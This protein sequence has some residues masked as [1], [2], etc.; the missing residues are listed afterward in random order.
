MRGRASGPAGPLPAGLPSGCCRGPRHGKSGIPAWAFGRGI[1]AIPLIRLNAARRDPGRRHKRFAL[2]AGVGH[3]RRNLDPVRSDTQQHVAGQTA[4]MKRPGRN[5]FAGKRNHMACPLL[6]LSNRLAQPERFE[7]GRAAKA[8]CAALI[9]M[10]CVLQFKSGV[11]HACPLVKPPKRLRAS[12]GD[13]GRWPNLRSGG[14]IR[15]V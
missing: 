6:R 2:I 3:P 9:H 12:S 1:C 15:Q 4:A 14:N 7:T 5:Q 10:R 11:R 8:A 13:P